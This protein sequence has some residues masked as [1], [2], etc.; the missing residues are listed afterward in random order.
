MWLLKYVR[1]SLNTDLQTF[2][3]LLRFL[4]SFTKYVGPWAYI[5]K[6]HIS[7]K[8]TVGNKC[9]VP[10]SISLS[11]TVIFM[12][13]FSSSPSKASPEAHT[14]HNIATSEMMA[15][16]PGH[17]KRGNKGHFCCSRAFKSNHDNS[18]RLRRC[19]FG[20]LPSPF[21]ENDHFEAEIAPLS[22]IIIVL[23]RNE[24]GDPPF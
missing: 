24:H 16:H 6:E 2:S 5:K 14:A 17:L 7:W 15:F 18:S 12:E 19:W 20:A 21:A 9:F 3:C 8:L 23:R 4:A 1:I 22:C 13:I 10:S 11:F